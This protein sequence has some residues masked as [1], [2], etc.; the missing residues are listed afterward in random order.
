MWICSFRYVSGRACDLFFVLLDVCMDAPMQSLGGGVGLSFP[1]KS[2][3]ES[4]FHVLIGKL[5]VFVL[6]L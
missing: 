6:L 4:S 5:K 1:G 2:M 3:I